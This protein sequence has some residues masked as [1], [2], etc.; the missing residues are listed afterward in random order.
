FFFLHFFFLALWAERLCFFFLHFFLC[1]V[2][3]G[4]AAGA[5]GTSGALATSTV[6]VAGAVSKVPAVVFDVSL[7]LPVAEPTLCGVTVRSGAVV[8]PGQLLK[9]IDV[10]L[11]VATESLLDDTE[12]VM[13]VPPVML[14]PFLPSPFCGC[15]KS[16]VDPVAPFSLSAITSAV[17]STEPS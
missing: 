13:D 6:N 8:E 2:T 10:G 16:L 3:A 12:T 17:L 1:G 15:T 4:A 5:E 11:T 14:Q 7:T 9:V